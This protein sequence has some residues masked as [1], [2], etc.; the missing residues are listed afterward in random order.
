MTLKTHLLLL[1]VVLL[2]YLGLLAPLIVVIGVSFNAGSGLTF[3]PAG[4]SLRWYAAFA[5]NDGFVRAFFAVSLPVALL[6][7]I[8]ATAIGLLAAIGIVR[9]RFPGQKALETF[10]LTPVFI[11]HILLGMALYLYYARLGFK[12]SVLSLALGHLVICAPYV[13]RTIAAS[14]A[15]INPRLEEAARSLGAGPV[16]AFVKVVMPLLFSSMMSGMT[17][18][19]II[20]FSDIN[21]SMFL[22]GPGVSTL[23][24]QILAQ[25]QWGG[26]PTIAAASALQILVVGGLLAMVQRLFGLKT[27]V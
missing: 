24:L 25:L 14:L 26:D 15:G 23:P 1:P 4:L 22:S 27:S 8:A 11:P 18:A 6:T 16:Q 19:F 7:A 20:S 9:F 2:V 17:F 21:L 5:A 13:V 3:P 12:A 10:F